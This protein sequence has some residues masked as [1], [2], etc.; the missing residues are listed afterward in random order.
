M[1]LVEEP[2]VDYAWSPRRVLRI[3]VRPRIGLVKLTRTTREQVNKPRGLHGQFSLDTLGD[4]TRLHR[5][6]RHRR[7]IRWRT[8]VTRCRLPLSLVGSPAA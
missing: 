7:D 4:D 2:E 5:L 3:L 8:N 1:S 6:Y